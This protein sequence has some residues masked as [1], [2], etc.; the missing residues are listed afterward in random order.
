[1]TIT[2][3]GEEEQQGNRVITLDK[4][5]TILK[6]QQRV[7][8]QIILFIVVATNHGSNPSKIDKQSDAKIE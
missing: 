8:I 1:M 3:S 4:I 2:A 6:I 7:Y 5:T